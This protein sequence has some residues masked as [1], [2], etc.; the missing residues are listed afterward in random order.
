M[1]A[2]L[3]WLALAAAALP[4]AAQTDAELQAERARISAARSG[5]DA[6]FA[7]QEAACYKKFAVNDC[8]EAARAQRRELLAEL[9]RQEIGLN[10]VER[11]R[12]AVE[13][14]RSIEERNSPEKQQ[15]D[16]AKR[17]E[18]V[19]RQQ[20]K[21]QELARRAAE[22]AQAQAS[23]PVRAARAPKEPRQ[24]KADSRPAK[25]Q[26]VHD[27]SEALRRSQERQQEAQEHRERIAKRLAE[28]RKDVKPLPVPP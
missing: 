28:G 6:R 15:E 27:S 9:R 23:A 19:A 1:K 20:D 5:A 25:E 4:L 7:A 26:R 16:A 21:Q 8:I 13:R 18:A 22:R 17:A 2:L 10:D 14:V 24:P 11:K 12:R 3:T